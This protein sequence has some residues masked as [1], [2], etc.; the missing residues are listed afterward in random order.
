[1]DAEQLVIADI[2]AVIFDVEYHFCA[3]TN[4]MQVVLRQIDSS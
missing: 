2:L 4:E 3:N 1:M